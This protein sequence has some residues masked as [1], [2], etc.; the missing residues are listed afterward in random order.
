MVARPSRA[1]RGGSLT[2]DGRLFARGVVSQTGVVGATVASASD[3]LRLD[4]TL[5]YV[6]E[7]RLATYRAGDFVNSGLDWIAR[8]AWADPRFRVTTLFVPTS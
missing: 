1:V 3:A 2:L 6:D 4:T 5:Q 7:D 8:F